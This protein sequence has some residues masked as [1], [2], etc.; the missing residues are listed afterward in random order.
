MKLPD[1]YIVSYAQNREDRI[2]GAFFP[3]V[4]K[5]FYV[6]V[7]ANDP[8]EDSVTKLFYE[9]GWNGINIEPNATLHKKLSETRKRDINLAVGVSDK[10]GEIDF[11]EYD[12]HG[13]STFSEE[14]KKQNTKSTDPK[15]SKYKDYRVKVKTLNEILAAHAGSQTI[16]FMK[17]DVEGYEYEVLAGN[18]WVKYRP[19]LLCIEANHVNHDWRPLIKKANYSL[20]FNDGLNEY[21]LR[22]ESLSRQKHFD[23]ADVMI[24]SGIIVNPGVAQRIINAENASLVHSENEKL[25]ETIR[26]QQQDIALLT[27]RLKRYEQIRYLIKKLLIKIYRK[28]FSKPKT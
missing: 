2:I 20:V 21:Y 15:L 4:T 1:G 24:L 17:V 8:D 16:N 28:V 25:S 9:N 6:D 7:G 14:A 18:D 23:Y 22:K 11:R 13:L 12:N 5:G 26:T 19:E 27:E 3:D 10:A